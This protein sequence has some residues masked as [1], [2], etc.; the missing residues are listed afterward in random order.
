MAA[1]SAFQDIENVFLNEL[2]HSSHSST[3]IFEREH[4]LRQFIRLQA[5][6]GISITIDCSSNRHI[7]VHDLAVLTE[8][9][10]RQFKNDKPCST[11]SSSLD[12]SNDYHR[13][14]FAVNSVATMVCSRG[15]WPGALHGIKMQFH[16]IGHITVRWQLP[17]IAPMAHLKYPP[18]R[19]VHR[20]QVQLIFV[21][22]AN[23][24]QENRLANWRSGRS[25]QYAVE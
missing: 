24:R 15:M 18:H 8:T 9:F 20:T 4:V 6:K 21:T 5:D 22:P 19:H 13:S 10:G 17:V 16:K 14:S 11:S 7:A 12:S 23:G 25:C 3:S 1:Y 2:I